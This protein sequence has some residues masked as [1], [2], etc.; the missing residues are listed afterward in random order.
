M[1][2]LDVRPLIKGYFGVALV[3]GAVMSSAF[4]AEN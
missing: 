2:C 4:D 1:S 3:V